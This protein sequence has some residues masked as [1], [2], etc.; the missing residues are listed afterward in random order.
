MNPSEPASLLPDLPRGAEILIIRLRSVGDVVLL[1]PAISAL[2]SWR[3]DLRISVLVEPGCAA[4]LEGN[5]AVQEILLARSFLA[6]AMSLYRR[7][8]PVVYN[9]HGGPTSAF[10]TA[11]SGAEKRVCWKGKQFDFLYNVHAPDAV[12]FYGTL[13]VHSVEQRMTQFYWTGLPRGP[14][15]RSAVFPQ[16]D[17]RAAVAKKLQEHGISGAEPYAVIQ[18]GA[19]YFTKQWSLENF[20]ATSRWL[21]KSRGLRSV[22]NL[23]PDEQQMAASAAAQFGDSGVIPPSLNLRELI[24]LIAGAKLFV[25]ND[26]GPSHLAAAAAVPAV[27][28]FGSTSSVHWRPWQSNHRVA[29][30]EF[31]CNPCKG[32]R[33]Y[34]FDEPRCI[35]SVTPDQVREAC[36]SILSTSPAEINAVELTAAKIAGIENN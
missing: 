12:E 1:T 4:V 10:L 33:C 14:I 21:W 32:D 6:T 26:T 20:A 18:P 29:Q 9:Q 35:L 3:P 25:G 15:P 31:A 7:N 2:H 8:F 17:A 36:E 23:G 22:V 27:V 30:N 19:R 24:A 11:A 5:P 13:Q 34:A 28:I 16:A